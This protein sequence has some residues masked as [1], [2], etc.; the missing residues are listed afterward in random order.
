[1][2]PVWYVSL[3]YNWGVW[4]VRCPQDIAGKEIIE[5]VTKIQIFFFTN[6]SM[7]FF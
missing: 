3:W 6:K 1:M 5:G 7:L 4:G 2:C